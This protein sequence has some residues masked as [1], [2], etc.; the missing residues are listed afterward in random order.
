M[1]CTIILLLVVVVLLLVVVVV[2][3]LVVLLC[4]YICMYVCIYIC[5]YIYICL[6]VYTCCFRKRSA[7]NTH[8]VRK[9]DIVM[10]HIRQSWSRGGQGGYDS[11]I[12]VIMLLSYHYMTSP[13]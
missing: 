12:Y 10:R 4:I 3:L 9:A 5:V 13:S 7:T 6:Y 8:I 2:L 11:C 1:S